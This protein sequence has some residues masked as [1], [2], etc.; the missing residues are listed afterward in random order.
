MTTTTHDIAELVDLDR[1]PVTDLET[2][3]ARALVARGRERLDST[4]LCSLPGFLR[5]GIAA[6][7]A[8]EATALVPCAHR[9]D[10]EDIAYGRHRAN[11]D[12]FPPDHPVRHTSPFRMNLVSYDDLPSG[13]G[14]KRIYHWDGLT[15]LIG[16][17]TGNATLHRTAD[18]LLSC[19]ISVLHPGDTHGWHVDG[20]D[21]SVTLLLQEPESGGRFE[22]APV[23]SPQDEN[24][25]T[26][27]DIYR[28]EREHVVTPDLK[29]GMLS[30]FRGRWSLHHVTPVEGAVTRL[31]VIF[32]YH[33]EPGMVFPEAT[34]RN[35]LGRAA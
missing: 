3:Q 12:S 14:I 5:P 32:S 11:L 31:Q 25:G 29:A 35:Y 34:R 1:Y 20:N 7:L 13:G 21:F 26:I 16:A 8:A 9:Q 6:R 30:I 15:R 27:A 33:V 28:G 24:F 18:P 22:Y 4:G 19:N 10:H 2:P 23:A 17:L